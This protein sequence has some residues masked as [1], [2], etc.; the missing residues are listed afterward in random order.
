VAAVAF[1]WARS[2]WGRAQAWFVAVPTFAL[3]VAGLAGAFG[4]LLPNLL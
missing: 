3:V 1:T 4:R 2:H